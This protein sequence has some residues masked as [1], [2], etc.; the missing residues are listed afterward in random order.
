MDAKVNSLL[1]SESLMAPAAGAEG[2][3][4]TARSAPPKTFSLYA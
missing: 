3:D 2:A 1:V 4:A